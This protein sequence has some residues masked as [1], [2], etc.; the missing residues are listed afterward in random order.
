[1]HKKKIEIREPADLSEDSFKEESGQKSLSSVFTGRSQ[2][3]LLN[4][5]PALGE[6]TKAKN[7]QTVESHPVY[8]LM[9]AKEG[10]PTVGKKKIVIPP[11]GAW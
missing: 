10:G 11:K 1:L 8:S 3:S 6:T 5:A 2:G 9:G 7:L 4:N